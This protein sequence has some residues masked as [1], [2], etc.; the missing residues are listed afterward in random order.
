MLVVSVG[1]E[2]SVYSVV[3]NGEWLSVVPDFKFKVE[4]EVTKIDVVDSCVLYLSSRGIST[5]DL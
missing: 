5:Y 3:K 2:V 1:P 4:E